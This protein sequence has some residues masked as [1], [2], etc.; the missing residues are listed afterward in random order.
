ME[1][2]FSLLQTNVLNRQTWDIRDDLKVAIIV[3]IERTYNHRR[4]QRG[5]GKLSTVTYEL[6]LIDRPATMAACT[7]QRVSTKPGANPDARS[8]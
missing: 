1:S 8:R 7:P 4:R 2:F 5:L 6:T 3:W